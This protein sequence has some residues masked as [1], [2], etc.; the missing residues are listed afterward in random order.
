M[1]FVGPQGGSCYVN[2]LW[3][4]SMKLL[5]PVTL[6]CAVS[7]VGTPVEAQSKYDICSA[8]ARDAMKA[9][10]SSSAVPVTMATRSREARTGLQYATANTRAAADAPATNQSVGSL[11]SYFKQ[12]MAR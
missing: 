11:Q 8:Y 12:C 7:A 4:I 6:A 10:Y 2:L 3:D 5:F 1:A 9:F